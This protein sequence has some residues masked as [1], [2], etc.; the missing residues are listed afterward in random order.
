[1]RKIFLLPRSRQHATRTRPTRNRPTRNRQGALTVEF[2]FVVP[3]LLILF[4][5]GIE[6]TAMNLA[7]QTAGNASYEGARKLI[8]P[9]GTAAQAQTEA[10]RQMN[11][12][13]LGSGASVAVS[14]TA[15]TAT[16]QVS[17]PASA[18]TWG[19]TGYSLG[20]TLRQTCTLTKE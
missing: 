1:M 20:L 16:V 9:G 7:R 17:V 15:T 4:F 6:L 2:A 11:L 14:E 13:G 8:I 5:G 12:V 3:V 10:I 19:L 18:V